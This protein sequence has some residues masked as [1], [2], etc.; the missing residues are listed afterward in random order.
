MICI[1]C[2]KESIARHKKNYCESCYYKNWYHSKT[3]KKLS[4]HRLNLLRRYGRSIR[5]KIECFKEFLE[6]HGYKVIKD[7]EQC[8]P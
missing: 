7:E 3:S 1:Q 4:Q 8:Q 6:F 2:N 5:S